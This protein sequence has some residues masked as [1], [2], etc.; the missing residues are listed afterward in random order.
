MIWK[1]QMMRI[2]V[3][4]LETLPFLVTSCLLIAMLISRGPTD[5]W[6]FLGGSLVKNSPA[7]AGD[8]GEV[9]LIPE[10]GKLRG[11][12]NGNPLQYSCL[13]NLDRGA[14]WAIVHGVANSQTRL[15][16]HALSSSPCN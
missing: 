9:G 10:S 13:E 11:E 1:P 12:R 5:K 4:K 16:M 8:T 2:T 3:Y 6:G 14:L 15:S 7:D